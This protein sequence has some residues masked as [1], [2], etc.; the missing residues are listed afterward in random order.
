LR[1]D[2]EGLIVGVNQQ[3]N[4]E[5]KSLP[6]EPGDIILFYTDGLI[7]A[8]NG[9]GEF[10]GIDRVESL[11]IEHCEDAPDM[12]INAYLMCLQQFCQTDSFKDD[13]TMMVFKRL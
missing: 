8:E 3:V 12:L 7:E 9:M 13:V 1:L 2:A 5:E 10:F 6:I 4:F 11:L